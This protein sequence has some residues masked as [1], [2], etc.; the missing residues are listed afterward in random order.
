MYG[1]NRWRHVQYLAEQFWSRWRKEYLVNIA[2]RQKWHNPKRNLQP[3]DVVLIKEDNLP[4]NEW[5]LARVS[6][7]TTNKDGLLRRVKLCLGDR[8]LSKMGERLHKISE[9]ERPV[10]KLVLLLETG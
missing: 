3:G 4:R 8:N 7:V 5:K 2:L 9:V 6:E 10:Q 1:Q